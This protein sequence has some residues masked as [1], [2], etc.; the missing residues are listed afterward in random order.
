MGCLPSIGGE[1][2]YPHHTPVF[3]FASQVGLINGYS[4]F[5]DPLLYGT[6]LKEHPV[7]KTVV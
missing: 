2:G 6:C 7:P 5:I 4:M 1:H 3:Y